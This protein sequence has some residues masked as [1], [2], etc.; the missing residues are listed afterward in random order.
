MP[1]SYDILRDLISLMKHQGGGD[2]FSLKITF[3]TENIKILFGL[4][5]YLQAPAG[6]IDGLQ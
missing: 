3:H 5:E 2:I 1:K 6:L 4:C